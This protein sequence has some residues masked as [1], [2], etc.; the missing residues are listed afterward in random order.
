MAARHPRVEFHTMPSS[1]P[2]L[3][4]L[5]APVRG[6]VKTRL[7]AGLGDDAALEL[8]RNFVSD[9]L[10]TIENSGLPCIAF[11]YPPDAEAM[12]SDWLGPRHRHLPQEGT[13]LGERMKN[14]FKRVFQEEQDRAIIIG[15]DIPDLPTRLLNEALESL[16]RHDCVIG[17][18]FDGGYYLI[19]FSKAG[20]R[21]GVFDNIAWSTEGVYADTMRRLK[22]DGAMVHVLPLRRDV[23]AIDDLRDFFARN[24][25]H[26]ERAPRTMACLTAKKFSVSP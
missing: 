3:L 17:P 10:E 2:I 7:A 1:S 26:P 5:K 15:S 12:V 22:R 23:D 8:Y 24:R 20:F 9:I 14:A 25:D 13:D 16:G 21:P 19:G 6:G 4:F 11:F 18:A